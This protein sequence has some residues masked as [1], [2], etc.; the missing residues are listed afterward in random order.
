ML[1]ISIS[2]ISKEIS[3]YEPWLVLNQLITNEKKKNIL[4]KT[5]Q[6]NKPDWRKTK[7]FFSFHQ[8]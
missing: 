2:I 3:G 6:R 8:R 5:Y 7:L 1:I 4:H